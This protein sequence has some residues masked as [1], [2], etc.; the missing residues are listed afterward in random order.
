VPKKGTPKPPADE[1]ARRTLRVLVERLHPAVL[2]V[3]TAP[4]GLDLDVADPVILDPAE[5]MPAVTDAVVLAVG[6]D[7]DRARLALVN[8]LAEAGAVA[9]IVKHD[10]ALAEEVVATAD[11]AGL[12]LLAAPPALA[13]GQL[14]T[15]LV[16]ATSAA[17]SNTP[18][19]SEAP[20]GDLFALANAVAAM[21][22]GATTIEDPHNRVLAY[23]SLEH[24][25]DPPRERTI[26]GRQVPADWIQR[27]H[28]AGV[29]RRLWQKDE[30]VRIADFLAEEP[31]YLP[32]IA[33][34]VRAGGE[35]LGSIWVIEG[36]QA[37]GSDAEKTLREAAD[38]AALHLLRHRTATDVERRQRAEAL[39]A[40]LDGQD[41]GSRGR[42]VLGLDPSQSVAVV[43]FHVGAGADAAAVINSHRVA[44]LV[45]VY[46]ESYRR[47]AACAPS[48]GR[49]YALVPAESDHVDQLASLAQAIVE[50]TGQA[51]RLGLRAGV[52]SVVE[53][54][55]GVVRSRREAD[56]V[57]DVLLA[58]PEGSVASIGAVR[59]Q[60]VLHRLAQLAELHPELATGKISALA[61][62]DA[63][64]GASWVPTLRAYFDAFG[65]MSTAAAM[66][67]V[68]PNTFRYR[69]RRITEVFG[70]D[71]ADPDERLVAEIQLR[72]L[73]AGR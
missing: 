21:V 56:D 53:G 73:D 64:K 40:V 68:H 34:A 57:L 55:D 4:R 8:R 46:C 61:E 72:F 71:L 65:D 58:R 38:I 63:S 51:L 2:D 3:V 13:W 25:I 47:Q 69:L 15:L 18:E 66:V 23:S 50:R 67:N 54:L 49:V 60:V 35:V 43:A 42:D 36:L 22:G 7:T 19:L 45:A 9:V 32:R 20:L 59:S 52:G 11:E 37:L 24:P 44:D 10:G 14:Y 31:G 41:R 6:V 28:D 30:V 33:V 62:Q 1:P 5:P 48:V 39:L 27:L 12:A 70:L 26:L 29:F 17:P 16:T